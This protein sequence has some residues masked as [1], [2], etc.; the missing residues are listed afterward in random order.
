M[1]K[2]LEHTDFGQP[3]R[4]RNSWKYSCTVYLSDG[5]TKRAQKCG[6]TKKLARE[7]L[8]ARIEEIGKEFEASKKKTKVTYG[9][10]SLTEQLKEYAVL[11]QSGKVRTAG[12]AS[13]IV[14][15]VDLTFCGNDIRAAH[16]WFHLSYTLW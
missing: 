16:F 8:K 2:K 1:A 13:T 4:D 3:V 5:T 15:S 9:A 7:A 10:D 14:Q 12:K 6:K 11:K